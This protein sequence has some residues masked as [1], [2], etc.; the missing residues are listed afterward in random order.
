MSAITAKNLCYIGVKHQNEIV[1]N[2]F[3]EYFNLKKKTQTLKNIQ[4][5]L[6]NNLGIVP[7]SKKVSQS[8]SIL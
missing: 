8:N 3:Q 1:I 2:I 6:P 4:Q 7:K 5:A